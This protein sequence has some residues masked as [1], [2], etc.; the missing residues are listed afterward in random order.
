M[1]S[2]I[3]RVDRQIIK[4]GWVDVGGV[5]ASDK[6]RIVQHS[7][8]GSYGHNVSLQFEGGAQ[9]TPLGEDKQ[10]IRGDRN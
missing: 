7:G 4:L 3:V 9:D 5:N 10:I 2:Q 6:D 8:G 1:L